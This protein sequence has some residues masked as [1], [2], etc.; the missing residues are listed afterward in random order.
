MNRTL[1]F[2]VIG[3]GFWAQYQIAAWKELE[4]AELVAVC[5]LDEEKALRTAEKFGA[6]RHYTNAQ[7]LFEK[8]KLDFVDIITTVE[9]HAVFVIMAAKFGVSA[10]CQKPLGPDLKT[11]REMVEACKQAGVSLFVHENFRWQAPIRQVREVLDSGKIGEVFKGRVTFCSAFP[12]YDNQPVLAELDKFI[13]ADIGSHVLDIARFLMGE[14]DNLRCLTRRVN[15]RIK[16]EDV[17]NV[18]M[19]M[20]SGAHC[21]VEMSYASLLE[22]EAFPETLLLIE[23]SK[24]SLRLDCDFQLSITSPKEIEK[25]KVSPEMY[26]WVNPDYAL[27]QSCMVDLNRDFLQALQEGRQAEITGEDNYRTMQLVYA[28]YASAESGQVVKIEAVTF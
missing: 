12:V 11:A 19:E 18:L 3:C 13:L 17:A 5:D 8:E 4:A 23:G 27:V 15:P 21:F 24:G 10:I 14:V 28:S 6:A 26:H 2:A 1:R 20:K 25:R 22:R 16:G 9:A 7:E